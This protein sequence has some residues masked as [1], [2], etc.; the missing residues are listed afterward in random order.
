MASLP[1]DATAVALSGGVD[2]SVAALLLRRAGVPCVGFSMQ[3]WDRR[4]GGAESGCCSGEDLRDARIVASRLGIPFYVLNLQE[5]F[6]RSVVRPFV[7]DYLA[8]RTPSPCVRCN[9]RFK[10]RE[11]L[12]RARAAGAERVATGHYA[13]VAL[14]EATGRHVLRRARDPEKDQSYF[15]HGLTQEQ[16]ARAAFPVGELTKAE[17]RAIAAEAGLPVAAKPESMDLCFAPPVAGGSGA[18]AFVEARLAERGL[19][20]A[21]G[22]IVSEDGRV[23]GEHGG[24]HRFTVGQRRGVRVP[25]AHPLYV[26]AVRPAENRVVVGPREALLRSR[27][28]VAATSWIAGA[29]PQ[30]PVHAEVQLRHRQRP[31]PAVVTCRGAGRSCVELRRPEAGIAPGQ[32]AVFYAGDTVLGGGTIEDAA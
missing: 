24:V 2:S 12:D 18:A 13:R 30:S 9:D 5:E 17:V 27:V 20:P 29:E 8:G 15:L 4:R 3:L 7:D 14:D 31:V 32:S 6:E 28:T 25:A 19:R 26:L 10:F 16:L 11:L 1:R 21:P 22:E 23:L